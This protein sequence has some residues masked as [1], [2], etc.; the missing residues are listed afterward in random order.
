MTPTVKIKLGNLFDG[1]SDL[2][3]LPCS[4][5]GSVTGFVARSLDDYLIPYPLTDMTLGQVEILPFEGGENLAQFVAYAASVHRNSSDE[6][7]ILKIGES[8]GTFSKKEPSVRLISAPLLGT[9][10]GGLKLELACFELAKG[11][12]NTAHDDATLIIR[13]LHEDDFARLRFSHRAIIGNYKKQIRVFISHT[14]KDDN[15]IKW[16]KELAYYLMDH[17]IQARVDQFHLRRGMDLPQWMSNELTLAQKVVIVSDEA[18]KI[19]ADGRFGGVGWET[20]II[21]GDISQLPPDS[22]K[23]QVVVRSEILENGL[24]IYLKSKFVFH[25]P[26]SDLSNSYKKELL[27]ELLDLPLDERVEANEFFI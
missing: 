6:K 25:A 7:V 4:T 19:K 14:S 20:M 2:I 12:T 13:V 5:T 27:K 8:L 22:T 1:P 18:Y 16:V 15:A 23:Y 10:Y 3:V 17:G 11:F 26:P 24:P 21:Q 9:G